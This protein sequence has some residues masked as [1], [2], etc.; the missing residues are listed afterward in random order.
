MSYNKFFQRL[1]MGRSC[2]S[3]HWFGWECFLTVAEKWSCKNVDDCAKLKHGCGALGLCALAQQWGHAAGKSIIIR[4]MHSLHL[5]RLQKCRSAYTKHA[6]LRKTGQVGVHQTSTEGPHVSFAARL[7]G[8]WGMLVVLLL[9][10]RF[11]W[12][13]RLQLW[14]W[15]L[16]TTLG[17]A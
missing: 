5:K 15:L 3:G 17:L 1:L 2:H 14:K 9:R 16:S 6:W 7:L 13:L 4:D 8:G 12:K 11:D 10:S